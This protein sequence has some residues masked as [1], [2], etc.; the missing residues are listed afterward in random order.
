MLLKIFQ[1]KKES[2]FG[3]HITTESDMKENG[4]NIT[5]ALLIG[6]FGLSMI[7]G[8]QSRK[9]TSDIKKCEEMVGSRL[10]VKG[11][12]LTIVSY[13]YF[14]SSFKLSNGAVVPAKCK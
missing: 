11:D 8:H 13:H 12:T 5:V 14:I 1:D 4:V 6:L 7:L 10:V 9:E 2:K 3:T